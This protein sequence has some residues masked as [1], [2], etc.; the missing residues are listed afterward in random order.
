MSVFEKILGPT[1]IFFLISG[2]T[3][4]NL[5]RRDTNG[6]LGHLTEIIPAL[7]D[8]IGHSRKII[9]RHSGTCVCV[10]AR[11]C[12]KKHSTFFLLMFIFA[13]VPGVFGQVHFLTHTHALT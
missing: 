10:V 13:D 2:P 12:L 3:D 5:S 4:I 6:Y 8:I 7:A 1:D 11:V 9:R